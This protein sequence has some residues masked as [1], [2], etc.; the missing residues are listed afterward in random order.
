MKKFPAGIVRILIP[1][2]KKDNFEASFGRIYEQSTIGTLAPNVKW[3]KK[4]TYISTED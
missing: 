3:I 1:M 4:S 2:V